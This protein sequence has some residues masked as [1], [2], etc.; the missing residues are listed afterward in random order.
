MSQIKA[1]LKYTYASLGIELRKEQM[2]PGERI[3][4]KNER[5][6]FMD[7]KNNKFY[8]TNIYYTNF[9]IVVCS[10]NYLFDV[11][12]MYIKS[13]WTKRPFFS[14]YHSC[15]IQCDLQENIFLGSSCP[16]YIY[17][18]FSQ[19][20]IVNTNYTLPGYI[21]IKFKHN[22]DDLE[23]SY[24]FLKKAINGKEWMI[25]FK[26]PE[27]PNPI[28]QQNYNNFNNNN[29]NNNNFNNNNFN[30][31]NNNNFNNNN[32]NNNN[33]NNY[34]NFQNYNN[35]IDVPQFN[36]NNDVG[37]N[38]L[39]LSRIQNIQRKKINNQ[40]KMISGSFN[41]IETFRQNSEELISLAQQIRAKL[42]ISK[43]NINENAS[44]AAEINSILSKIGFIDPVTKEV[45]GSDY[46]I[47]L[48]EQ[49]NLYFTD[50]F[51]KNPDIKVITLIDAYCIYN[52][53]RGGNTISPKDMSQA[54]DNFDKVAGEIKIKN[55][56]KEMIVLHTNEFSN[57]NLIN[58][59]KKHMQ[60]NNKDYI[61]LK[62]LSNIINVKNV[63]LE[64]ILIDDLLNNGLLLIDEFDL[65]VR[66]YL[67]KILNYKIK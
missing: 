44:Q 52:R 65:D 40:N 58:L 56:N 30:N 11:P 18:S 27:P 24:N 10:N 49:I 36:I 39:G 3:I 38:G 51:K 5:M 53:A 9:R 42:S 55:F 17:D 60:Q 15:Y 63:L 64:T 33:F 61:E 26:K 50:Y 41:N 19:N 66:Y 28:Q 67:N 6:K 12:L 8:D 46:Y 45:A 35:N 62:S 4:Y 14:S 7:N 48:A 32:F 54:I 31:F 34:N 37:E 13:H 16:R 43:A 22:P 23:N 47:K 25:K 2:Y 1:E 29:F 59:I 20:E 57:E 21:Q